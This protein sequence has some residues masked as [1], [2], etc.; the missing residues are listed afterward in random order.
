[1]VE[2]EIGEWLDFIKEF[3]EWLIELCNVDISLGVVIIS[4]V[5]LKVLED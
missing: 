2:G 3:D 4:I 5:E 1:M